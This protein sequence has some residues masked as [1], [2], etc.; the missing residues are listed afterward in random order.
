LKTSD[1]YFAA[2]LLS[3]G[4]KISNVDR[5]NPR[6]MV[7]EFTPKVSTGTLGEMDKTSLADIET[8]WVNRTLLLNGR[9]FAE[10]IKGMK[11][12]IHSGL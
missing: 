1:V 6:H 5:S 3:L 2:A 8:Q 7:F 9:E 10:S 12:L 4:Y 11:S